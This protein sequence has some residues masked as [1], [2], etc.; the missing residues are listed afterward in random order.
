[1]PGLLDEAYSY[2]YPRGWGGGLLGF[3][4]S[5]ADQVA[6][7]QARRG[8]LDQGDY[9]AAI[10]HRPMDNPAGFM[11]GTSNIRGGA[12]PGQL[13][14]EGAG[15][16]PEPLTPDVAN[17]G[18]PQNIPN[19]RPQF[20]AGFYGDKLEDFASK[21]NGLSALDNM[22]VAEA[23]AASGVPFGQL[24]NRWVREKFGKPE[25]YKYFTLPDGRRLRVADHPPIYGRSQS[26]VY[27]T[28]RGNQAYAG[29]VGSHGGANAEVPW[30]IEDLGST[31]FS[32]LLNLIRK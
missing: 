4:N 8:L 11:L 10:M 6:L 14:L 25:A 32:D 3:G 26:D 5:V 29:P 7:D 19:R 21:N 17:P 22:T 30:N 18:G 12:P 1:M 9:A 27:L 31:T 2:L 20:Q 28:H 23:E 16:T 24:I 13:M 15:R